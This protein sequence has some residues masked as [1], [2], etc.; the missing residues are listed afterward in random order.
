MISQQL[1]TWAPTR[2]EEESSGVTTGLVSSDRLQTTARLV[3]S[4]RRA[5]DEDIY[6]KQRWVSVPLIKL[7]FQRIAMDVVGHF[8]EAGQVINIS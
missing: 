3:K 7:P 8:P 4:A 1:V 5:R 6:G 2:R